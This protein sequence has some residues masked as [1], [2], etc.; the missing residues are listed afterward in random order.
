MDGGGLGHFFL[1]KKQLKAGSHLVRKLEHGRDEQSN[2][3]FS[4]PTQLLARGAVHGEEE[5]G[6]SFLL[7]KKLVTPN[8]A[9]HAA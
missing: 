8:K 2:W 4:R 6:C 3:C 7:E 1:S 5:I 9:E